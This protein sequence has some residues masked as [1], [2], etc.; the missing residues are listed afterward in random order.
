MHE[1]GHIQHDVKFLT[2]DMTGYRKD[3]YIFDY[4][5]EKSRYAVT[6]IAESKP[7]EIAANI[8]KK[9]YFRFKEVGIKI[10]RIRT[11]NGIEHYPHISVILRLVS[12]FWIV[13]FLCCVIKKKISVFKSPCVCCPTI[14][15]LFFQKVIN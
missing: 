13:I 15:R 7:Q 11:D 12:N 9:V 6:Y 4:I 14:R 10:K 3:L 1:L 5:D 2:K 8:F